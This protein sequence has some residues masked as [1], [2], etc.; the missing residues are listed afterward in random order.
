MSDASTTTDETPDALAETTR[1]VNEYLSS[2]DDVE[3]DDEGNASVP[4]GSARVF[5]TVETFDQDEAVVK[6]CATVVQGAKPTPELFHH[7]ATHQS[8]VGH[9]AA[10]EEPDGTATITFSH[11]LLG[12]FLNP[13]ELR[14]TIVAV[15][16][17]ADQLDDA[18]AAQFGGTVHDAGA[19]VS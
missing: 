7:V 13:A 17:T 16:H 10:V 2:F 5:I 19:N 18:L 9:L 14:L 15:A 1:K 3:Q 6:A 12:E 11:S 4:W 8:E